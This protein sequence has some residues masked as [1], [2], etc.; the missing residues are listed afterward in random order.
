MINKRKHDKQAEIGIQGGFELGE[1]HLKHCPFCGGKASLFSCA[2][3]DGT[4]TYEVDCENEDCVV[5][6]CTDMC[7]TKED[8][9]ALWN[10]RKEKYSTSD[11]GFR[12]ILASAVRYSM[13]RK[14]AMPSIVTEWIME[15]CDDLPKYS[16]QIM[17]HDIQE[18]REMGERSNWDSLGD[19]CDVQTWNRFEK[20]LKDQE[21]KRNE[22]NN[23]LP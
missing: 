16:I 2:Q 13:G 22:R 6:A 1:I 8:A 7:K 12:N 10:R 9:A 4:I 14:S 15:H 19:P 20:W 18:Q 23:A 17:L 3:P 5:N 21:G 11:A